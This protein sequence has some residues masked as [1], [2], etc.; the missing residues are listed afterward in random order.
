MLAEETIQ[1]LLPIARLADS[2]AASGGRSGRLLKLL[3]QSL[4]LRVVLCLS[5]LLLG[6]VPRLRLLLVVVVVLL[7]LLL[8]RLLLSSRLRLPR[9]RCH[10]IPSTRCSCLGLRLAAAR[11]EEAIDRSLPRAGLLQP[12]LRSLVLQPRCVGEPAALQPSKRRQ[13]VLQ[14]RFARGHDVA[15]GAAPHRVQVVAEQAAMALQGG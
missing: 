7:L 13:A 10:A 8:L 15:H 2:G 4:L 14:Q 11:F 5:L 9:L 1:A 3:L 6:V 12:L